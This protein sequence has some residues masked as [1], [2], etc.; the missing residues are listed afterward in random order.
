[1][2]NVARDNFDLFVLF[3]LFSTAVLFQLFWP[4]DRCTVTALD[5]VDVIMASA[6]R[7]NRQ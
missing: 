2:L 1:M 6:S 7:K 3:T 5:F 4:V